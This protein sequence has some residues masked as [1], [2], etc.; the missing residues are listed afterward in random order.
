MN[1]ATRI[2]LM[3]ICIACTITCHTVSIALGDVFTKKEVAQAPAKE[4]ARK[5][6]TNLPGVTP[7]REAA[8][9][10]FVQQHH[11]DLVDLLRN[12]KQEDQRSYGRAIRELFMVSERLAH[13]QERDSERYEIDLQTWK[14]KSR[15]QYLAAQ[16]K[17]SDSP[18]LR[19]QLRQAL[20]EQAELQIML[21]ELENKRLSQRIEQVQKNIARLK[22]GKKKSVE[23]KFKQVV[24][25]RPKKASSSAN[26]TQATRT[27]RSAKSDLKKNTPT[28][29]K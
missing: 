24:S 28:E 8:V 22:E 26:K 17:M 12:L 13:A 20:E 29:S 23:R 6:P 1:L 4:T 3:I 25:G 16:I 10:T 11:P 27:Q 18:K 21:L 2:C 19:Q 5:K 9:M 7:E 14:A 15:Q